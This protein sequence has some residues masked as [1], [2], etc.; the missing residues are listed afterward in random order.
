MKMMKRVLLLMTVLTSSL[1]YG[2]YTD[3]TWCGAQDD[4]NKAI[5]NDLQLTMRLSELNDQSF[6]FPDTWLHGQITV[7]VVVHIVYK[8]SSEIPSLH[9]IKTQIEGLNKDFNAKNWDK[10]ETRNEFEKLIADMDINFKL[11]TIDPKGKPTNGITYTRTRKGYFTMDVND[12]KFNSTQGVDA[13]DSDKYLNIWVGELEWGL[14][15]YAQ[16]PF[17]NKKRTDGV[18]VDYSVFGIEDTVK[19]NNVKH[20]MYYRVLTHEVGHWVGL[21]HIWGDTYCGDDMVKDTPPQFGPHRDCYNDTGKITCNTNDLTS[22]Y[23]DY[24]DND[25]MVMFTIEQRKRAIKAM[26]FFRKG[27]IKYGIKLT[28]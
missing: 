17:I 10:G 11:A 5:K 12:I 9:E 23:M 14:L 26:R 16:F 24:I 20:E 25:C 27:I 19:V 4:L 6:Q 22:N 8:D 3:S 21:Y 7:P 13:W 15:G 2:Q 28:K 1:V 18:V